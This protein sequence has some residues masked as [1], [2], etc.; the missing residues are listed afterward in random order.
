[1][2]DENELKMW[3]AV[4]MDLPT[5]TKGKLAIQSGHAFQMLSIVAVRQDPEAMDRYIAN[6]M[7]K[8]SVEVAN[9]AQLERVVEEAKRA[10]IPVAGITDQGRT[11]FDGPTMT[12]AAFGPCLRSALP[13]YLYRLQMMKDRERILPDD[14]LSHREAWRSALVGMRDAAPPR[15][16]DMDDRGYW[17]HE[18]RAFDRA[19][20]ELGLPREE[21]EPEA[22]KPR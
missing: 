21:A 7:P 6:S 2:A 9:Q 3:L 12:V 11:C 17:E 22:P 13:K 8:V 18:L 19:Y 15:T 20:A 10:G 16:H 4:R 14:F 1:M 5:M